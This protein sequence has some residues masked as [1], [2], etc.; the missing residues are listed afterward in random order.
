MKQVARA[1]LAQ[2]V[3]LTPQLLQSIR[4]LQLTAPQLEQELLQALALNPMLEQDEDNEVGETEIDARDAHDDVAA[5]EAA[6]WDELPEPMHSAPMSSGG[7]SDDDGIARIAAGSST[8]PRVRLLQ[9]LT[10]DWDLADLR[11][12]QWW[13]DHCDDRGYLEQP[14]DELTLAGAHALSVPRQDLQ[15]VRLRLL[16][17]PWPGM[18]AVDA[19]ECLRAQLAR[20]RQ[21]ARRTDAGAAATYDLADRILTRH[22]DLLAAHDHAALAKALGVPRDAIDRAA[23]LILTL[24]PSAIEEPAD[25]VAAYITPDVVVRFLGG[26]WRVALNG[27]ATPRIRVA[28]HCERA[29]AG[30]P[31]DQSALRG[32]LDEARWLVRGVAMRNDT[33]LRTAQV[34]AE[35]Q[36]GFL[37]RGDEAIAPLTLREVADAIGMHE[38]TVSRITTGK[39]IQTPRGTF[40]L[41]RLFAVRLDGA[42]VSGAAVKAMVKRLIDAE[43]SHA[44]LADD[45]IAGL[46]ERQGVRI[47]RRTVAKYRDQLSI[48]PA[49]SRQ[50]P[51]P[52]AI[53]G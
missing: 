33:L 2:T 35:R 50:R 23:G 31:G 21:Q 22:I 40:E 14:L 43:P 28:A 10:L 13:L 27:R 15:T 49:R 6:A 41:K 38:S 5:L 30:A 46:L 8:D 19:A 36:R 24:S 39:Y 9:E 17:G 34:L 48:G 53:T 26:E 44:P 20:Q 4:L 12:A 45:T 7:S 32:L 29:L 37:E 11:L 18:A 47:A 52:S 25:A 51:A 16:H 42:T 1:Q 3:N